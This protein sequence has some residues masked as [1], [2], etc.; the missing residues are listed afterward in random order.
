MAKK[1][2]KRAWELMTELRKETLE[3]HRMR[4][5][6]I[7]FKITFVSTGIGLIAAN[8]DKV[9]K[10]LM[11]IPAFASIFFDLLIINYSIS[12]RRIGRYC[13]EYIEPIL[14]REAQI[15]PISRSETQ[16]TEE[17]CWWEEFIEFHQRV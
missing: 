11:A 3:G 16:T 5:Q 7:G 12:I 10:E 8:I 17:F 6:V 13:Q 9:P 2:F 4:T 15:N 1:E 14:K